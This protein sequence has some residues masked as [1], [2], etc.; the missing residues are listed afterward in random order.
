MLLSDWLGK[1]TQNSLY[2]YYK[3]V[4]ETGR[5]S[6]I[7]VLGGYTSISTITREHETFDNREPKPS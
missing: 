7:S 5:Y 4:S 1:P 3:G 6:L 2:M